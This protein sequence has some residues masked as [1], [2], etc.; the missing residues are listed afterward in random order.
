MGFLVHT[1]Q[2]LAAPFTGLWTDRHHGSPLELSGRLLLPHALCQQVC[3]VKHRFAA[4]ET[5]RIH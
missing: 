5:D 4:G 1:A 3:G 2:Q